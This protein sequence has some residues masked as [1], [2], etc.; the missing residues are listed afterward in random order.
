VTQTRLS[1]C[2]LSCSTHFL[3]N[4]C[5]LTPSPAVTK[6]SL[7]PWALRPAATIQSSLLPSV[8]LFLFLSVLRGPA[9]EA[10]RRVSLFGERQSY[11]IV[12]LQNN[13]AKM[14][15]PHSLFSFACTHLIRRAAEGWGGWGDW[16]GAEDGEW[17]TDGGDDR[18]CVWIK[19]LFPL[20]SQAWHGCKRI[21]QV[22]AQKDQCSAL[23]TQ[24]FR[25]KHMC[26]CAWGM[27]AC[28]PITLPTKST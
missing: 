10:R 18:S 27:W 8:I 1:F 16:G 9:Y 28:I 19:I 11:W 5:D 22:I 23:Y 14:K 26:V 17:W 25:W 15:A 12:K 21:E 2:L 13:E 6:S 3:R 20:Y 4:G 7:P 24:L